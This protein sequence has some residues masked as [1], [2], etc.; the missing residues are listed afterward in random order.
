MY[1][2]QDKTF[3]EDLFY[4]INLIQIY[5]PALRER[6]EDIPLLA[7]FFADRQVEMLGQSRVN[8]APDALE[9]L[10]RLSFP[11][12]IRELKNLIDRTILISPTSSISAKDIEAQIMEPAPTDTTPNSH[13]VK[14]EDLEVKAIRAA[15]EM[16]NGNLSKA[17]KSLGISRAALYRRMEK[18]GL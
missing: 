3:R 11:G 13:D 10:E 14:L 18:H 6:R 9:L 2:R 4:R 12:N 15:I 8:F 1:E 16:H 5:L 17:A 7:R